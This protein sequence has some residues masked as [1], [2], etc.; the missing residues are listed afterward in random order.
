M[1]IPSNIS[2]DDLWRF[3]EVAPISDEK[4]SLILPEQL[5]AERT[6][7]AVPPQV[8]ADMVARAKALEA[9]VPYRPTQAEMLRGRMLQLAELRCKSNLSIAR[10]GALARKSRQQ[11]YKEISARKLL[12]ISIGRRITRVPDWQLA[13]APLALTQSVLAQA[14]HVDSWTIYRALSLPDDAFN[15]KPPVAAVTPAKVKDVAEL[16]CGRLGVYG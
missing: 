8:T 12:A 5:A 2:S 16:I 1:P 13:P 15:G 3:N 10:Y 4:A 7:N 14:T 6:T 11:L 9:P